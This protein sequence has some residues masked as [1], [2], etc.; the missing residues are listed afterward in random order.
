VSISST[1]YARLFRTKVFGAAFL[2]SQFGFEIFWRQNIGE[3][4]GPKMLMKLTQG[5]N[6][7]CIEMKC[8]SFQLV[9][10]IINC[11]AFEKEFELALIMKNTK[12]NTS[13]KSLFKSI[14]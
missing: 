12:N 14:S 3:K 5:I 9:M 2:L 7:N 6:R 13:F 1:F 11:I 10:I 8:F 4:F